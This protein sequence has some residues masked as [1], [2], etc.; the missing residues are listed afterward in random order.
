MNNVFPNAEDFSIAIAREWAAR[1]DLH[2][3]GK[4]GLSSPYLT[5]VRNDIVKEKRTW[6]TNLQIEHHVTYSSTSRDR[7]CFLLYATWSQVTAMES[8]Q[9]TNT[10]VPVPHELK[11]DS[12]IAATLHWLHSSANGKIISA[13][14]N[15]DRTKSATSSLPCPIFSRAATLAALEHTDT[16]VRADASDS[17]YETGDCHPMI[18]AL[19]DDRD[20]ELSVIFRSDM[21]FAQIHDEVK[22]WTIALGLETTNIGP[23]DEHTATVIRSTT[24]SNSNH[25]IDL[26][27]QNSA[28]RP[29]SDVRAYPSPKDRSDFQNR[30]KFSEDADGGS[31]SPFSRSRNFRKSRISQRT[32]NSRLMVVPHYVHYDLRHE[33][34]DLS[35]NWE[36][37][38]DLRAFHNSQERK[39]D[40][41]QAMWSAIQSDID[42]LQSRLD[43]EIQTECKWDQLFEFVRFRKRSVSLTLPK[44]S[45]SGSQSAGCFALLASTIA[46]SHQVV[47]LATSLPINLG[48]DFARA[49]TQ[50]GTMTNQR[51]VDEPMSVLGLNGTGE[52]IG[53]SDSG[54]DELSCFFYDYEKGNIVKRDSRS[55]FE[56]DPYFDLSRRK[57]VQY[58]AYT[59]SG[60]GGDWD[61]GHGSHTSGTLA[62]ECYDTKSSMTSYNGMAAGAKL[63]FF[64]IGQ[65]EVGKLDVPFDMAIIFRPAYAA[66]SRLHSNSW[67][68]GYWYDSYCLEVDEFLFENDDFMAV[69]AAGNDGRCRLTS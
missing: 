68:G 61:S 6:L 42:E 40:N 47:R 36:N 10:I 22:L 56:Q 26:R 11:F 58:V 69:F 44:G 60:S 46:S 65:R 45:L 3:Q 19:A 23:A 24:P 14:N 12:S 53:I 29:P 37:K 20:V 43:I 50:S 28:I 59:S 66:G 38:K 15:L 34:F 13:A 2:K 48:N 16:S 31:S 67:G 18:H 32:A 5:C 25:N 1:E 63:A 21:S 8:D 62:G 4:T 30:Y 57:V 49:T 64:D 39:R 55:T 9:T 54:L 33:N 7:T 51:A 27:S 52:V 17:N 35:S 41:L